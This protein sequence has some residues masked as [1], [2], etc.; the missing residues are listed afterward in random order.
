MTHEQYK[1]LEDNL[2]DYIN[3]VLTA[4]I[5]ANVETALTAIDKLIQLNCNKDILV[6]NKELVVNFKVDSEEIVPKVIERINQELLKV[7]EK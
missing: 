7:L 3:K 4:K 1:Q 2:V 6:G 5:G